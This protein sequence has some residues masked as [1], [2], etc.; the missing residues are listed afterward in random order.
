MN[1]VRSGMATS[2]FHYSL[3]LPANPLRPG[4]VRPRATASN[5]YRI[6]RSEEILNRPT[7][8]RLRELG[9]T[10]STVAL[11]YKRPGSMGII[12][13]DVALRGD[14]WR[15]NVAA[16]NWNLSGVDSVMRWYEVDVPGVEPDPAPVKAIEPWYFTLNGIHFGFFGTRDRKNLAKSKVRILGEATIHGATLVRTDVPHAVENTDAR[17]GRLALSAR[18][19]PDFRNWRAAVTAF[20]PLLLPP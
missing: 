7:F 3:D 20:G 15:P 13:T 11:F 6:F 2:R 10:I 12:H 14:R 4:F 1:A 5:Y 17:K 16:I 19:E 18:C 8:T 9:L